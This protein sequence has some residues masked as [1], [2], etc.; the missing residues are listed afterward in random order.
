MI[1]EF[2]EY[3]TEPNKSNTKFRYEL[4]RTWSLDRRLKTWNKNNFNKVVSQEITPVKPKFNFGTD[5]E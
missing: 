2:Y 1:R 4:E 5:D 3:W